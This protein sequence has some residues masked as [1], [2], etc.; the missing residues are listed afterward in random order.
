MLLVF[1]VS[2]YITRSSRR[3]EGIKIPKI[4]AGKKHAKIWMTI[5]ASSTS[6]SHEIN[7]LQM[8]KKLWKCVWLQKSKPEMLYNPFSKM[9]A[10]GQGPTNLRLSVYWPTTHIL[11][12]K[13]RPLRNA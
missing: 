1:T 9:A 7:F 4:G 2:D 12:M 3:S 5:Q 10:G 6:R 11:K 13:L 8:Q